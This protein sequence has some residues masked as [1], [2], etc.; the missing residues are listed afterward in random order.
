VREGSAKDPNFR[1]PLKLDFTHSVRI[2]E[3]LG[4]VI[5]ELVRSGWKRERVLIV[6]ADDVLRPLF[7]RPL[8]LPRLHTS[9]GFPVLETRPTAGRICPH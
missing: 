7:R 9:L 4:K 8:L 2:G 3:S 6:R 5:R 1:E